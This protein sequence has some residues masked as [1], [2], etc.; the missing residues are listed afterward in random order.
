MGKRWHAR[1]A[2]RI[3]IHAE[4]KRQ[5]PENRTLNEYLDEW[6]DK[7]KPLK[8]Q[9]GHRFKVFLWRS[10]PGSETLHDRYIITDQCGISIPGGLDCRSQSH[11]N[12][13]VWSLLD[14]DDRIRILNQYDP[15]T[16]PFDLIGQREIL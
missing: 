1:L 16:S 12:S 8:H 2:G 5:E 6:Q 11:A 14:E 15:P 10:L 3:N 7:L 4:L 9:E 13:T